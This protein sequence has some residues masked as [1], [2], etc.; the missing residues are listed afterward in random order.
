[1]GFKVVNCDLVI[2]MPIATG[3]GGREHSASEM[4]RLRRLKRV[5]MLDK[6]LPE[7]F[8]YNKTSGV[9]AMRYYPPY[10]S[11]EDQADALGTLAGDLIHRLT[12]VRCNDIHT[13]NVR[14]GPRNAVII[15]LGL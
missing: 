6:F 2:K 15:D 10:E 11:F 14:E 7:V 5:G 12:R 9:I 8:Y 4:R 13:D 1:L 3:N